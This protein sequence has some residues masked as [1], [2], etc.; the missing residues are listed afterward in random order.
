MSIEDIIA[1]TPQPCTRESLARDLRGLGVE[2]GMILLVHSS[3]SALGWV[4]G[5]AVAVVQALID[6]LTPSGTLVMPTHSADLT[7]P[8]QWQHPPVPSAWVPLIR[9]TMPAY[10]PRVTPTNQMGQIVETFRTWPGVLRSA[11]PHMSFAA[12][13]RQAER[14]T[15]RHELNYALGEGSPLARIYELDGSVL[16]LGVGYGNNTSFHL[17]EYRVPGAEEIEQGAPVYGDGLRV[18]ATLREIDLDTEAFD[19]IGAAFEA[20]G[21]VRRGSVGLAAARLF[22]QRPAVDFATTWLLHSR[23]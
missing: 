3:L 23:P 14:V 8:A 18:W 6:V 10:D 12:W 2:P 1:R 7:D 22:C 20:T 5:G 13:G 19:D 11:H 21:D 15:R 16:L 17:A 4:C 9:A